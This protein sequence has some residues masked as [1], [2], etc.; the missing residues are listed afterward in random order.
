MRTLL[1]SVS[2]LL[3]AVAAACGPIAAPEFPW[4]EIVEY[5]PRGLTIE[6]QDAVLAAIPDRERGIFL[7]LGHLGFGTSGGE[8]AR[9]P[10]WV[11]CVCTRER[12]TRW[13]RKRYGEASTSAHS[14][15][16]SDTRTC[17]PR[18]ATRAF[19]STRWSRY[20]GDLSVACRWRETRSKN[21]CR[22]SEV[23]WSQRESNPCLQGE[24]LT[25]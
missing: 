11:T 18:A 15:P 10:A 2:V 23:W 1:G 20:F 6:D 4:V 22:I 25:S 5:L 8:R 3:A 19:R 9:S 7:A 16:S 21:R 12:S 13:R 17:V 14:R 24:N